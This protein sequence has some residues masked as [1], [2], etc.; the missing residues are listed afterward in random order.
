LSI[1]IGSTNRPGSKAARAGATGTG[2]TGGAGA[3]G[4]GHWLSAAEAAERLGVKTATLYAYVSRGMLASHRTAG[5]RQSRFERAEVERLAARSRAPRRPKGFELV[6]GSALTLIEPDGALYYRGRDALEM[7]RRS[8][9]E[10][11]AEWLW[12][13]R[14]ETPSPWE[15]EGR[16]LEVALAVQRA[17]PDEVSVVDRI[18]ASAAVAGS[19]DPFRDDRRP[20][21]VVLTAR[22]LISV[23]VDALP[24]RNGPSNQ[25][26][27]PPPGAPVASRLW[28]RLSKERPSPAQLSALDA[29]LVLLADHELAASTLAARIAASVWASPYLVVTTGLG[30]VGGILH[31]GASGGVRAMLEEIEDASSAADVLGRRLG[32]DGSVPGF[33]HAVYR[34][35]DPR[36]SVLLDLLRQTRA[37]RRASSRFAVDEL[38]GAARAQLLPPPNIDLALGALVHSSTMCEDAGEAIFAVARCAGWLAHAL[39]EYRH[40][41]RFRLRAAYTGPAPGEDRLGSLPSSSGQEETGRRR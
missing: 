25:G 31:G 41:L 1:L 34:G 3:D 24:L 14:W 17:L 11:V 28:S 35:A 13:G 32:P 33:G 27:G 18:R 19:L 2:A 22:S 23:L 8:T 7:A 20:A 16:S 40:R 30:P 5:R 12:S 21:A 4:G 9:Y 26:T 6:V 36:C 10:Q 29:A 15:P 38:L 39:E 37:G